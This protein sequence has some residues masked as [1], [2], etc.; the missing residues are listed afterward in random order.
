MGKY[1]ELV[2][3]AM[4]KGEGE[5]AWKLADQTIEKLRTKHPDMYEDLIEGLEQ[6]AYKIPQEDAEQIV[7]AMRPK[8]QYWSLQQIRDFLRSKGITGNYVTWYLVMNMCYNDFYNTAKMYNLQGDDDFFYCL[9]KDF[10]EDPDAKPMK[11]EK[12]FQD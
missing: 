4:D 11:V 5:E 6:L 12:Y 8:G 9:A 10:I 1:H 7:R 3:M 2:K